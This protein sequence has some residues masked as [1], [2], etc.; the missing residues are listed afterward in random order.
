MTSRHQRPNP[1]PPSG[2]DDMPMR[3][4]KPYIGSI[5]LHC[6]LN[7]PLI[8][9]PFYRLAKLMAMPFSIQPV[10]LLQVHQR[11]RYFTNLPTSIK[12]GKH[13]NFLPLQK[14]NNAIPVLPSTCTCQITGALIETRS[15]CSHGGQRLW[16][17]RHSQREELSKAAPEVSP[18]KFLFG[19]NIS[20][21]WIFTCERRIA[22]SNATCVWMLNENEYQFFLSAN[23]NRLFQDTITRN[24]HTRHMLDHRTD[25]NWDNKS[26]ERQYETIPARSINKLDT[27]VLVIDTTVADT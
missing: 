23:L 6:R 7:E 26:H 2:A 9:Q 24:H 21:F 15:G 27:Y 8:K 16:K 5:F 22:D 18:Y 1:K 14:M 4:N 17:T 13:T 12:L 20:F 10:G 25:Y 11:L 3:W 19:S